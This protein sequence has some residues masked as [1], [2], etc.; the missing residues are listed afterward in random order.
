M[1]MG[2]RVDLAIKMVMDFVENA[3][4]PRYALLPPLDWLQA[5][6]NLSRSQSLSPLPIA[7]LT[8]T[9]C[10]SSTL[11]RAP[12]LSMLLAIRYLMDLAMGILLTGTDVAAISVL[13]L[14]WSTSLSLLKSAADADLLTTTV[15]LKFLEETDE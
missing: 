10:T 13:L 11:T 7:K 1:E 14:R 8:I 3:L 5:V 9:A 2:I 15:S 4:I 12:R 6:T